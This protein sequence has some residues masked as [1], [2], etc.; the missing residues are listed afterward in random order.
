MNHVK[1]E[2]TME[3]DTKDRLTTA[4]ANAHLSAHVPTG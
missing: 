3:K 2:K 1:V 4:V